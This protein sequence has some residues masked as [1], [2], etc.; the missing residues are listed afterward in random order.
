MNSAR[1]V[2]VTLSLIFAGVLSG[3]IPRPLVAQEP[4]SKAWEEYVASLPKDV[5]PESGN[6]LPLIERSALDDEGKKVFDAV[7]SNPNT[8]AGVR[9][10]LGIRLYSSGMTRV[11]GRE[12]AYLRYGSTISRRH[13]ELIILATARAFDAQFEWTYHELEGREVGLE[14]EVIDVVKYNKPLTGLQE[15]DAAI[16]QIGRE[17][18]GKTPVKPDTFAQALKLFGRETLV[19][20]VSLMGQSANTAILLHAFDQQLP[21]GQEPLLPLP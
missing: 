12:T 14:Q 10:P 18:F 5:Y 15:Q 3:L 4:G 21:P 16:I 9:G 13:V 7:T 2:F 11:R 20:I 6:R 17:I 19:E 1:T 8:L